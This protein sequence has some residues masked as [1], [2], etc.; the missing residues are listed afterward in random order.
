MAASLELTFEKAPEMVFGLLL[1]SRD[2][3]CWRQGCK[4]I[5]VEYGILQTDF[6]YR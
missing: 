4:G 6:C 2:T 5:F 3:C 1:T